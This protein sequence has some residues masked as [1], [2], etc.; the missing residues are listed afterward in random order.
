MSTEKILIIEDDPSIQRLLKLTLES[1]DYKVV[2]ADCATVGLSLFLSENPLLVL[3][4]LG[5]PDLDG[6]EILKE[7]RAAGNVP[8]IVVSA[9]DQERQKVEALDAGAD[10]YVVKP[11][12]TEELFARIRVALRHRGSTVVEPDVYDVRDLHVDFTRRKIT[13]GGVEVHLTPI[14]FKLL[15]VLI[16]N[17]GKVLTHRF[18]QNEVWGYPTSDDYQTLRVFMASLRRKLEDH[19][20]N[21]RF[22]TTEV[23]VGYRFTDE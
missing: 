23:G 3:L 7:I 11:F 16:A 21:P 4:D 2:A 22:I 6:I 17:H 20:S 10:D 19:A 5:L 13:V 9:R 12:N 8:I 18:I 1:R 14:E 15:S